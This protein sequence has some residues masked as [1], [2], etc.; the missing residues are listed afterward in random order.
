MELPWNTVVVTGVPGVG[1]TSL[2]RIVSDDLGYNYINYGDLM[3]SIAGS[4]GLASTDLQMFSL[5]IDMQYSIWKDAALK[6]KD[7]DR[8]LVDLHGVDQSSIGYIVSLPVEII[9]PDVIVLIESSKD[10]ILQRRS[11]DSKERIIDTARSL[12]EHIDILRVTMTACSAIIGCN[13]KILKNDD[14]HACL[15]DMKNILGGKLF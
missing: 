6:I 2:C 14:F 8:V 15:E 1:K 12:K 7:M 9:E 4:R 13:L 3:L 5:N 10:N 11:K